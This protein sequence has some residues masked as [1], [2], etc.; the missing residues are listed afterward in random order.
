MAFKTSFL[1]TGDS[2][3][4]KA[5][6]DSLTDSVN[7][8]GATAKD[9]AAPAAQMD[10]AI[11]AVGQSANDAAGSVNDLGGT[12]EDIAATA[13][14]A[15]GSADTLDAAI[16]GVGDSARRAA[17]DGGA[18]G[19]ILSDVGG[20]I[21]DTVAKALGLDNALDNMGSST[22]E[23][24]ELAGALEDQLGGLAKGAL[25][26]SAAQGALSK[27][28]T[29]AST[30]VKGLGVSA[31]TTEAVLTGGL[32]L[33]LTAA[34]GFMSGFVAEAVSGTTA[35]GEEE[36]AAASLTEQID[37]LNKAL[38]REAQTQYTSRVET[39]RNAESKRTLAVETI[40]ARK[41]LLETAAAEAEQ[42]R[43]SVKITAR[44]DVIDPGFVAA[45]SEVERLKAEVKNAEA[46]LAA[47]NKAVA[48]SRQYFVDRGVEAA[49][50]PRARA[51]LTFDQGLDRLDRR[52]NQIS[53]SQYAKERA[54][55]ERD[56]AAALEAVSEAEKKA[57][58]SGKSLAGTRSAA[59][60]ADRA[61]AEATKKLQADLAGVV[62]RY[63]PARKAASDYAD[64]LER[65]ARLEKE[66]KIS[67]DQASDY[68]AQASAAYIGKVV[69]WGDV[70]DVAA[71]EQAAID[72][73]AAIDK[74]V[75]SIGDE[76]AAIGMLNPVQRELLNYRS[77]LLALSP[78]EREAAQARISGALAEKAA[79]QEV[80]RAT[81]EARRAQEQLGNMA[82][83]AFAAIVA[84]GQ[85]ASDVIGRLAE[86]IAAAAIQATLFGTGPLAAMLGGAT[87]PSTG[88][89]NAGAQGVAADAI[90]KSVSKSL[91]GSLDKVFGSKGS[92]GKTLQ[93][94]GLGYA[95]GSLTG[96]KTGGALG[97][98]IGGA[99]GKEL[100]GSA[101]GSLGQFAGPIGAIAG[102]LLGGAIGGLLKKTKT[103]SANITSVTDDATVSGNS[104]AFKQ[105]AAGAAGSVQDGLSDIAEM[106]GGAIGAF[107]VTIGQRHGDWRVRS[108]TGSLKVAKGAT[109][110]DDDQAG[111]IAYAIQLAVS[112]GAV[113]G[114][115][116][117]VEKALKSSTDLDDA[118]EE[119]LKVQEIE[120]LMGGLGAELESQFKAFETQAKERVRIATQYGFDVVAI[121]KKNAED[122][123]ALVEQMLEQ[124][125]GSLQKLVDEMTFGSMF[126]GSAVEQRDALLKEIEKAKADLDAGKDGA[127]D[128]LASL[129]QQLNSVSEEAYGSTGQYAAD[130]QLILDLANNEIARA[131]AQINQAA[132]SASGST[133]TSTSDP[134]LATTNAQLDENNDQ[135][136]R[137]IALLEELI[138]Q[139]QGVVANA[140]GLNSAALA[141]N[142]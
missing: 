38:E 51:N 31:A 70:K 84:G 103:G 23:S 138:A 68:K 119:A 101:L 125:V 142:S 86:T 3:T 132:A 117:A 33:A 22:K 131:T 50:D 77:Q 16:G 124:Q 43:E 113:T 7:K 55:L 81:E 112:Q 37:A 107:N 61:A 45:A 24:S 15:A 40:K 96:S 109:E 90:G 35:L 116:A 71:Q 140:T 18:L 98:A 48:S 42:R 73:S 13:A 118:L 136:A 47:A 67:A 80:Q 141:W 20:A 21:K 39:L 53:E 108:G 34:I 104:S 25:E 46:A 134:A 62:G 11:E 10:A 94:A 99:V 54:Q 128:T 6:V 27:A 41:A 14:S 78:E 102:G 30:A 129:L 58:A 137:V 97:G 52:R 72:A 5:A 26:S 2:A 57:S 122:R 105:A 12:I 4:A 63:D 19:N 28:A 8:L 56:R 1:I 121:E 88:G 17:G 59:S 32:S 69:D 82:V 91:E 93:N 76:T 49:T 115:S 44:G 133:S 127:A 139:G 65:I 123:A 29:V 130:R 95:A 9:T 114:L 135:N 100:L 106:L 60:A 85:K 92:F 89:G 83:D 64:E 75:Q 126:A 111:A 110:F 120:T 87:L 74:I 79:A 36:K 66:N